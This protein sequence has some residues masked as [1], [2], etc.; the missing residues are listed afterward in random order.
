MKSGFV[1]LA[2][3]TKSKLFVAGNVPEFSMTA[4]AFGE[5]TKAIHWLVFAHDRIMNTSLLQGNA[6]AKVEIL[7][8]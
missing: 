1:F 8:S 4:N 7:G 6:S 2:L 3:S 5:L